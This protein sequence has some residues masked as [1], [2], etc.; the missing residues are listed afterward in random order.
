VLIV[1]CSTV[2]LNKGI[3]TQMTA[4]VSFLVCVQVTAPWDLL[5]SD[6]SLRERPPEF[7]CCVNVIILKDFLL[8]VSIGYL[9]VLLLCYR[10]ARWHSG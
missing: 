4:C 8:K 3:A 1:P 9:N 5:A 7:F 10:G 2:C 6:R